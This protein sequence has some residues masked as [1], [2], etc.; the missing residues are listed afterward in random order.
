M[1][2]ATSTDCRSF[3]TLS[4]A[5]I[6]LDGL[7]PRTVYTLAFTDT[8]KSGYANLWA[9][10]Q[11]LPQRQNEAKALAAKLNA[12]RSQYEAIET[13]T[14]IP[15]WWIACIHERES[16][17]DFSTYLGNGEHVVGPSA[18]AHGRKTV[19]VPRGRGPFPSFVAGAIDALEYEGY[20]GITD[21]SLP[22]ALYLAE[23]YNG[24]GYI[25]RINSPYV[26]SWTNLYSSGK[27]QENRHGSWFNPNL[28]DPQPGVAAMLKAMIA[29]GFISDLQPAAAIFKTP[30]PAPESQPTLTDILQAIDRLAAQFEA[31]RSELLKLRCDA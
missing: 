20:V 25:G 10:A 4:S 17:T 3:A 6:T 2:T 26:W 19:L 28:H 14:K 22:H 27:F 5:D 13:V 11:I 24:W 16:G 12:H 7:N 1:E 23:A 18:M 31:L 9:K 8:T 21:W 15:W 30:Q 29:E